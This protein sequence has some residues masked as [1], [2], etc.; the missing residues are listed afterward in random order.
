MPTRGKSVLAQFLE[1]ASELELALLDLA[2]ACAEK[3]PELRK[4]I[5]TA[6]AEAI[7]RIRRGAG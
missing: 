4:P 2:E 5:E 6:A 1:S 7:E 3:D